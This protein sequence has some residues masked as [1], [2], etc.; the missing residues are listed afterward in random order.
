MCTQ[1]RRIQRQG[2]ELLRVPSIILGGRI[3]RQGLEL[4]HVSS[5]ILG[6]RIQ[7]QG[8]VLSACTQHNPRWK[9]SEAGLG[10]SPPPPPLLEIT[11]FTQQSVVAFCSRHQ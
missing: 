10:V 4:L 6:G 3:Q 8:W 7:R 1:H 2:L 5:I 11:N 9:D